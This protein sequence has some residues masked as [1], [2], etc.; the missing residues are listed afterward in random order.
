MDAPYR[1]TFSVMSLWRTV[2]NPM[3][4]ALKSLS[5]FLVL[6]VIGILTILYATRWGAGLNHDSLGYI[7]SAKA[8]LHGQGYSHVTP[9]GIVKP[10]IQWPPLFSLALTPFAFGAISIP[11]AA[12]WLNAFLFG[13]NIALVGSFLHKKTSFLAALFG[14]LLVLTST[15]MLYVHAMAWTEPL[16]IVLGLGGLYWLD[17]Y[18]TNSKVYPLVLSAVCIGAAALTRYIGVTLIV[19]LCLS[20]LLFGKRGLRRRFLNC[21][22]AGLISSL[23]LLAFLA[24]NY[25][26]SDGHVTNQHFQMHLMK[27]RH[28][29]Q[30]VDTLAAWLLL[31]NASE[32]VKVLTL[33]GVVL[34]IILLAL[35][36]HRSLASSFLKLHV[37]YVLIY[38]LG[39]AFFISFW[40][41]DFGFDGRYLSPVFVSSVLILGF[42]LHRISCRAKKPVVI[43][44]TALCALYLFA[45]IKHAVP[46]V[47]TVRQDGL[48]FESPSWKRAKLVTSVKNLPGDTLIYANYATGIAFLSQRKIGD[49]P[50]KFDEHTE[51]PN[52]Y[53]PKLQEIGEGSKR[54]RTVIL[55]VNYRSPHFLSENELRQCFALKEIENTAEGLIYE[56]SPLA[57]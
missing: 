57:N 54:Q 8:L 34:T 14:S 20:I 10:T 29:R 25:L 13:V 6:G 28:F 5:A 45:Y 33:V 52:D 7:G 18:V 12:R 22:L 50:L 47:K 23:P 11:D 27:A 15:T 48:G 40:S 38:C 53:V 17:V 2:S 56:V 43:G 55:Y 19:T 21:F 26:V 42:Y 39:M 9:L 24:R 37:A 46:W 31:E 1:D 35:W 41:L 30:A 32:T 49:L 16:Y 51:D 44:L 4:K 3:P 36:L